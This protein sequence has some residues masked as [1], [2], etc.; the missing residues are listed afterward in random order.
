VHILFLIDELRTKGGG[1]LALLNTLRWLPAERFRRSV[2][3]FRMDP[4]LPML[5]EF[6]CP[7]QLFPL[8]RTYDLNAF[9]M[10]MR[11]ARYIHRE[12]VDIVHS[13]FASSDLWGG[14][15]A[16]MSGRA[17]LV[18]SRRDMG[19]QRTKMHRLAYRA[20]HG[21]FDRV[22]TVSEQVRKFSIE[23]DA[24]DPAKV[25]TIY[26]A[27]EL[28]KPQRLETTRREARERLGIDASAQV[29]VS[30]GNLRH[31]K[32]F[33]VLLQAAARVCREHPKAVFLIAGGAVAAEPGCLAEL[34]ALS[35]SLGVANN[36]KFLGAVEDV[37]PILQASDV[38]CLLS[39]SEGFSNALLEAMAHGIA[40]VATRVGGNGEA[41]EDRHNGFLVGCGDGEAA[42]DRMLEL[43]H[44]PV[45]AKQLGACARESVERSFTP[46]TV[47]SQLVQV[48]ESLVSQFRRHG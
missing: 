9:R 44:D 12:K 42:A 31:V 8:R 47:T 34:Q 19:F 5:A 27:V 21:M 37:T 22:V 4:E 23:Q 20:L 41:L 1:E 13:F 6:P 3:T 45:L 35:T 15:I 40:C 36:I 32:G 16:K 25:V 29:I 30:V 11:L 33:D 24:L 18:S 39:R 26:N 48:Y 43:L 38:F 2:I 14:A 28:S 46:K 7:L 17:A 10:G